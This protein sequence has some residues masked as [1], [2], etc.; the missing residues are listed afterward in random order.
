MPEMPD[1]ELRNAVHAIVSRLQADVEEQLAQLETRH[2]IEREQVRRDAEARTAEVVAQEWSAKLDSARAEVERVRA[3]ADAALRA[4]IAETTV[5]AETR[6]AAETARL[7]GEAEAAASELTIRL[8]QEREQAILDARARVRDEVRQEMEQRAAEAAA[9]LREEIEEAASQSLA[10]AKDE[11]DASLTRERQRLEADFAAERE[12]WTTEL[13]AERRKTETNASAIV[14]N[15]TIVDELRSE[16]DGLRSA[17]A[18]ERA[19]REAAAARVAATESMHE[20]QLEESAT[21]VRAEERQARVAMFEQLMTAVRTVS[22]ARSLSD[23]LNALA[24]AAS[25]LA[26]RVSLFI[27]NERSGTR[28]LQGWR[29]SGFPDPS[30]AMLKLAADDGGLLATAASSRTAISTSTVSAPEFASLA[31]DRAALAV[32]LTVGGKTV[33]VLYAD[34][35]ASGEA[36]APSSWPEAMQIL[37][38]HASV[39]LSH[40]TAVRTTQAMRANMKGAATG[41][42]VSEEDH[43]ARRYARLLVSEIK[44]YNEAA[45]RAGREKRDLLT[46]LRPEI[47]RARR[48]YEERIPPSIGARAK[49]FQ[50]ELVHT[51]ADG[52]AA[53]L[54]SAERA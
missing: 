22:D 19:A 54:G 45:V 48:L 49:Y 21:G 16:I 6:L 40:I 41:E 15:T 28:E 43:S 14:A 5:V 36:E 17:L 42:S 23:T 37:G 38:A 12:R 35:G 44:L 31:P 39:C 8:Q 53:L 11:H 25:T 47:E 32:P 10:R 18:A 51:L 13:D 1:D 9:R 52:D 34:D 27:L 4:E 7:L 2:Q 50:E 29:A 20:V 3:E 30:P 24:A 33:A 26:P 46:R